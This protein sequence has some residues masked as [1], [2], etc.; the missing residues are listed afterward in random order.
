MVFTNFPYMLSF[1]NKRD[2]KLVN[3]PNMAAFVKL[4][5]EP[6]GLGGTFYIRH[7]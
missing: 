4:L 7:N 6:E 5:W 3:R 1:A 2:I